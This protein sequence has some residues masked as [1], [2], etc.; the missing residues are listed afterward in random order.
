MPEATI[1]PPISPGPGGNYENNPLANLKPADLGVPMMSSWD[2]V[3]RQSFWYAGFNPDKFTTQKRFDI[4]DEML[5]MA[6]C[7]SPLNVLLYGAL[8]KGITVEP[9]TPMKGEPS[10]PEATERADALKWALENIVDEAGNPQDISQVFW[11]IGLGAWYGFSVQEIVYRAIDTGPLTG[12]YGFSQ[13]AQKPPQMIGF[14]LDAQTMAVRNLIPYA[15]AV[16]YGPPMPVQ[17]F[18]CYTHDPT[19][20]LPHG[21]GLG[22]LCYKHYFL[23]DKLLQM[24]SVAAQRSG[25]ILLGYYPPGSATDMENARSALDMLAISAVGAIPNN[26]KVE[27]ILMQSGQILEG[28]KAAAD[29]HCEQMSQGILGNTLTTGEGDRSGSLALGN[30]HQDTGQDVQGYLRGRLEFVGNSQIAARWNAA[31]YGDS[32]TELC[33]HLSLGEYD[34]ADRAAKTEMYG[35]LIDKGVTHAQSKYIR[36][37]LNLPPMDPEEK[38]MIEDEKKRQQDVEDRQIDAKQSGKAKMSATDVERFA[39]ALVEVAR[40]M[41]RAA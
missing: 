24:W 40:E 19:R 16:G 8:R 22:R 7:R 36:E 1:A 9:A 23:L 15:P 41:E 18:V 37:D 11:G 30:V 10:P 39:N 4:Y 29:W 2:S 21:N 26:V 31:N 17:K 35:T 34:D 38:K 32:D 5:T 13:F 33:P 28:F 14:D 3:F 20:G 12:K 6:A 27:A 25:V